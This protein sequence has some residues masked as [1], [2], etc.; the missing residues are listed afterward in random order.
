MSCEEP[1][2]IF[3]AACLQ[4]QA[5][6][7]GKAAEKGVVSW[8]ASFP[9]CKPA[10]LHLMENYR[11]HQGILNVAGI[12][13]DVLKHFFPGV[14]TTALTLATDCLTTLTRSRSHPLVP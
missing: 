13:L 3:F 5:V 4:A 7:S 8:A 1:L 10:V 11:S 14:A 6:N 2:I 12:V 9:S